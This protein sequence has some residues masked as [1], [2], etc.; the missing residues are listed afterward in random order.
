MQGHINTCQQVTSNLAGTMR[1]AALRHQTESMWVCVSEWA[2]RSC[3]GGK[4]EDQ[5]ADW[6]RGCRHTFKYIITSGKRILVCERIWLAA[7]HLCLM[8]KCGHVQWSSFVRLLM[9]PFYLRGLLI[10]LLVIDLAIKVIFHCKSLII[11]RERDDTQM[12]HMDIF[13]SW[14]LTYRCKNPDWKQKQT[15]HNFLLIK[16]IEWIWNLL[17]I[18]EI[19]KWI[20][21]YLKKMYFVFKIYIWNHASLD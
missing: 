17:S 8:F 12:H 15:N 11:Q 7:S 3:V 14:I 10:L 2:A 6:S 1:A 9:R 16:H 20:F 21:F 13:L 4:G 18:I 19:L 5:G